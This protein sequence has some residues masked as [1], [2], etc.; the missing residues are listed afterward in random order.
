M[1]DLEGADVKAER[2]CDLLR[3]HLAE[4]NSLK[5]RQLVLYEKLI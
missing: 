2:G 1:T 3:R 4:V 5:I